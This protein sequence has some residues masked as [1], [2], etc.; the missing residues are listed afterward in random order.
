MSTARVAP[1]CGLSCVFLT[2]CR[3]PC[4]VHGRTLCDVTLAARGLNSPIKPPNPA[5]HPQAN[6]AR[7]DVG[8]LLHRFPRTA[9]PTAAAPT[10]ASAASTGAAN[11]APAPTP[12]AAHAPPTAD[13]DAHHLPNPLMHESNQSITPLAR[14][15]ETAL[16]ALQLALLDLFPDPPRPTGCRDPTAASSSTAPAPPASPSPAVLAE[17]EERRLE[18]RVKRA[19]AEALALRGSQQRKGPEPA[20]V[21]MPC[22]QLWTSLCRAVPELL[23]GQ[24]RRSG[25]CRGLKDLLSEEPH[26]FSIAESVGGQD[27]ADVTMMM[28]ARS[29]GDGR[30]DISRPRRLPP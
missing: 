3:L 20:R 28:C 2:M 22:D 26:V 29:N 4:D 21:R 8:M 11:T 30:T 13:P 24:W 27:G 5:L 25:W 16:V 19:A 14:S 18:A 9:A 23:G 10:A 12:A 1:R 17:W 6:Y 7:L 15:R